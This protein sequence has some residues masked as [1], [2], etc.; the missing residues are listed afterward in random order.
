MLVR[1]RDISMVEAKATGVLVRSFGQRTRI[2]VVSKTPNR[3][4]FEK[5]GSWHEEQRR[6]RAVVLG[7]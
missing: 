5:H 1:H 2:R 6:Q 3:I 7:I 4:E